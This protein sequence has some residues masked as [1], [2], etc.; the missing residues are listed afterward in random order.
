MLTNDP[1]RL[2][3][4]I[5]DRHILISRYEAAVI[6]AKEDNAGDVFKLNQLLM[7]HKSECKILEDH[8]KVIISERKQLDTIHLKNKKKE[9]ELAAIRLRVEVSLWK[10]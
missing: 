5:K 3:M 6:L 7:H 10:I 9:E 4:I 2:L 1:N 8:L